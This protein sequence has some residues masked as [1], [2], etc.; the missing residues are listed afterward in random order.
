M[1]FIA[2]PQ[3]PPRNVNW[4]AQGGWVHMAKIGFEKYF[5][6]KI[7]QGVSEPFYEKLALEMIG[8]HKLK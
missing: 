4:S 1:V 5:L 7:K 8:V 3:I 2:Q 6:R